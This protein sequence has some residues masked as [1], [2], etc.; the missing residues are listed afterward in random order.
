MKRRTLKTIGKYFLTGIA[1]ILVCGLFSIN[2][3]TWADDFNLEDSAYIQTGEYIQIYEPDEL[4]DEILM[5]RNGIWIV[6]KCIGV[7]LNESGDGKILNTREE[8]YNY[9][10]Y[11]GLNYEV[12][13]GDII[14][15]YLFYNPDTA[16]TDDIIIR[17]DYIIE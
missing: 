4:N 6:E 8:Y 1:M 11:S 14:L 7:V 10:N 5:N 9:I 13:T 3:F 2:D 15:T 17:S 12:H 16:Y